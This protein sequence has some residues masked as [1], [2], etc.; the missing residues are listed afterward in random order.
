MLTVFFVL[1][2]ALTWTLFILVAVAVPVRTSLGG[3][4]ALLGAFA[5]A[6]VAISLTWRAGG[7]PAPS[8]PTQ[9]Q[10]T[11]TPGAAPSAAAAAPSA[12]AAIGTLA[13]EARAHY[14]RAIAAQKAGDWAK[15][16][17]E[18]RALGEA[19]E[20]MRRP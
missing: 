6:I 5:P 4:M 20:R 19:L 2:Y 17:E 7:A 18:I 13:A 15:Y 12:P 11:A 8:Q 3:A 10:T 9:T 14:D 16:G 1:T